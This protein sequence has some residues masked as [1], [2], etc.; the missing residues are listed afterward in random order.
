MESFTEVLDMLRS[1]IADQEAL[2]DRTKQQRDQE[3]LDL[4]EEDE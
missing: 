3:A 2:Q 4:L 1:I